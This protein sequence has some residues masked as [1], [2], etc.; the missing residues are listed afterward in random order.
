[1]GVSENGACMGMPVY[2]KKKNMLEKWM[3]HDDP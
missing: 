2:R 1:M 3:I